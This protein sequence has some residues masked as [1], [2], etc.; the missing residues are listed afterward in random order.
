M[1]TA[2]TAELSFVTFPVLLPDTPASRPAQLDPEAPAQQ[3]MIDFHT[4]PLP[5]TRA[6]ASIEEA[7][8]QM[9]RSGTRF[10]FVL[11]TDG[12]LLGAVT[13]E[14]IQ[15]EKPVRVLLQAEGLPG[16]GTWRDVRV[17]QILQPLADWRVIEFAQVAGLR[18]TD[19]VALLRESGQC[20]LV[21]VQPALDARARQVRGLFSAERLQA[22]LGHDSWAPAVARGMTSVMMRGS[23]VTTG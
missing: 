13:R 20:Y 23:P 16:G 9:K 11:G 3:A 21:V 7:L 6:E 19:I 1:S 12:G 5:L 14:D 17:A 18:A 2:S 22:L 10:S 8:E 15:S 4:A